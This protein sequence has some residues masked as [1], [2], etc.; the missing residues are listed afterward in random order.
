[1]TTALQNAARR[2]LVCLDLT[3]LDDDCDAAAVAALCARAQT[4]GGSVAA[5]CVWPRF[6]AQAKAALLHTGVRVAT[7]VN[8][9]AGADDLEA[10]RAET[11]AVVGDGADEID[12]VT[13]WRRVLATGDAA[14]IAGFLRG[15]R[16]IAGDL[17]VKAILETGELRDPAL[18]ALAAEAAIGG[19]AAFLKTSTGKTPTGATPE[20][21][22][23]LLEAIARR[24]AGVGFKA[25]GGVRATEQAAAYLALADDILGPGWAGPRRFRIGASSLLDALLATLAG[26]D[27]GEDG[28]EGEGY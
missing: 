27:E 23:I 22:R 7:V 6:V 25:S 26:E 1:M 17:P 19:G 18:I 9:P 2:A 28:G 5:V 15:I 11:R 20:A 3:N 8:F 21:A 14:L 24:G 12:V 10:A 4:P 13:P 16:D